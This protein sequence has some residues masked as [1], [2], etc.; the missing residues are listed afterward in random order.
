MQ[1]KSMNKSFQILLISLVSVLSVS[2]VFAGDRAGRL[3]L[4]PFF[5]P[6]STNAHLWSG[7]QEFAILYGA[8]T[9]LFLTDNIAV[10]VSYT[11]AN[12][13]DNATYYLSSVGFQTSSGITIRPGPIAKMVQLRF[14]IIPFDAGPITPYMKASTGYLNIVKDGLR[15]SENSE[16]GSFGAFSGK[17]ISYSVGAGGII[18]F[19]P[20]WGVF[21]E[22]SRIFSD[23][24][25]NQSKFSEGYSEEFWT[26]KTGLS[27]W[28]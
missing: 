9:D 12:F 1:S 14:K 28:Y 7:N 23:V 3:Q 13:G 17:G 22:V 11:Y 20:G 6:A 2:S 10:G 21:F 8:Q 26:L 18:T 4:Q 16:S 15:F 27:L 25:K 24:I 5:G 19:A